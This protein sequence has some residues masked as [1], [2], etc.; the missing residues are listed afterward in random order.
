MLLA[1]W[2]GLGA[3]VGFCLIVGVGVMVGYMLGLSLIIHSPV[4]VHLFPFRTIF[5]LYLTVTLMLVNVIS[6]PVSHT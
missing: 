2:G 1:Y 4:R 6:H 3:V 5:P